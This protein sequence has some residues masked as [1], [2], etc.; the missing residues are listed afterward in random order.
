[1]KL[2]ELQSPIEVKELENQLDALMRSVGLDVVFTSHFIERML[3][4]D[5][6]VTKEE[7]VGAFQKLKAKYKQRLLSAKKH[8]GYEA[9]LKDFDSDLN[10]VFVI[11]PGDPTPELV[12]ITM[13]QKDPNKFRTNMSGGDELKV[14]RVR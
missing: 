8:P 2:F 5:R 1:M 6:A 13:M 3:G 12:N 7:I 10:V 11:E 4:R 14:G 9:I